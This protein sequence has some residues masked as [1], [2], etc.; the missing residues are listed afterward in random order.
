VVDRKPW[1]VLVC[2]RV[3]ILARLCAGR[4]RAGMGADD[5]REQE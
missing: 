2:L 5:L 1:C 4:G 3:G